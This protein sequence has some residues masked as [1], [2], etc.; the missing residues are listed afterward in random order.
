MVFIFNHSLLLKINNEII[1][2]IIEI[3]TEIELF[4]ATFWKLKV[5]DLIKINLR[6]KTLPLILKFFNNGLILWSTVVRS[7][8][9]IN[10]DIYLKPSQQVEG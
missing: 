10:K 8:L 4:I 1:K 7:I 9:R 6:S 2:V 5:K 3:I